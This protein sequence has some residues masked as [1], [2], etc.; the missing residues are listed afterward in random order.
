MRSFRTAAGNRSYLCSYTVVAS[1]S[2]N[3]WCIRLG[4]SMRPIAD[5]RSFSDGRSDQILQEKQECAVRLLAFDVYSFG[6]SSGFVVNQRPHLRKVP[7]SRLIHVA[8][9]WMVSGLIVSAIHR[10]NAS[11]ANECIDSLVLANGLR[12]TSLLLAKSIRSN[13]SANR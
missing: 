8:L 1:N 10:I 6:D 2:R 11:A 5:M 7:V 12:K 3:C 4:Q 9:P 13:P